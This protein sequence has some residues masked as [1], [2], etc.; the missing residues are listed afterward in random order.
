MTI[1]IL[2]AENSRFGATRK[3]QREAAAAALW[4][5]G[6]SVI[7]SVWARVSP[8]IDM[9]TNPDLWA[10]VLVKGVNSYCAELDTPRQAASSQ[11]GVVTDLL[12][13]TREARELEDVHAMI[14]QKLPLPG[15]RQ[16][17][18]TFLIF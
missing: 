12:T 11:V 8:M 4:G 7:A 2:S 9:T 15:F 13:M 10:A 14:M 6:G 3:G 17:R 1:K 18:V 16:T 5:G